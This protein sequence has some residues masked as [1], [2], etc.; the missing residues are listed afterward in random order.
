MLQ[1]G[2]LGP[3]NEHARLEAI[4]ETLEHKIENTSGKI[5]QKSNFA[6][7]NILRE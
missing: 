2:D 7:R 4:V 5:S 6:V 1:P 3:K